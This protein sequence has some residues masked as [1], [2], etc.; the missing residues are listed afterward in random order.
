MLG[1]E[2]TSLVEG[3]Y[4]VG[5]YEVDFNGSGLGSGV[6]IYRINYS[7]ET[8]KEFSDTKKLMLVK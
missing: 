7:S 6:Y 2:V 4:S 3:N 1:K 5:T 8:G